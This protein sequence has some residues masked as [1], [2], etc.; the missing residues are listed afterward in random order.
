MGGRTKLSVLRE[1]LDALSGCSRC[2][3]M[4]GPAIGPRPVVSD[5]YLLG[6]APGQHEWK[7]GEPFGWK[8]GKRL[9]QWFERIGVD[10]ETFRNRAYLAAVCRCFPGK[11]SGDGDRVPDAQEIAECS[12]WIR[13]EL[14][15]MRPKLI[16]PV[17]RLAIAQVMGPGKLAERVG[18]Q[19]RVCFYGHDCDA[20]P[21]PH[22][23]G[24]SSWFK[25]EPGKSLL[26]V[27]LSLL[28]DHEAF[29]PLCV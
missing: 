15:L 21:L 19:H 8:A 25:L 28:R 18:K 13:T 5:V 1:H 29:A 17:G 2:G 14:A 12:S 10:E 4:A 27:A 9:F 7:R 20:I 24:L 23:S 16:V 3:T 22:P 11:A 26:E 6:Q